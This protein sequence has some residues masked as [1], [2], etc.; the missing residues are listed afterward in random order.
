[1]KMFKS[2]SNHAIA[3]GL[4]N[5]GVGSFGDIFIIGL[6]FDGTG[7]PASFTAASEA[8][9]VSIPNILHR[10]SRST[11]LLLLTGHST[12]MNSLRKPAGDVDEPDGYTP[13][14]SGL[15]WVLLHHDDNPL[16]VT[17]AFQE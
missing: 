11:T 1:M 6:P 2:I 9:H 4:P 13:R 10:L 3:F 8:C 17:T 15:L 14:W 7:Q 5:L 16:L 12:R